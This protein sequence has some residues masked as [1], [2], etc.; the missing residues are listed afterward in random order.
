MSPSNPYLAYKRDTNRLLYWIIGTSNALIKNFT[1]SENGA[2][3]TLNTTGQ[4]TVAGLVVM[5]EIIGKHMNPV[6]SA[7]YGLFQS[8]IKARSATYAAFQQIVFQA[9]RRD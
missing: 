2:P 3:G 9:R 6:P 8:V 4:T 5:A 1:T 7:I